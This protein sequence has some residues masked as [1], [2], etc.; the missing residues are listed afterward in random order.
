MVL[1]YGAGCALSSILI[2]VPPLRLLTH[3]PID[4]IVPNKQHPYHLNR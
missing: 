1:L 4:R 2:N 3:R